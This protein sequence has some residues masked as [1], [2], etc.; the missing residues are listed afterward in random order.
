MRGYLTAASAAALGRPA[1]G[2]AVDWRALLA[3][4]QF[5][6]LFS[7]G[8]KKSTFLPVPH[9]LVS[10]VARVLKMFVLFWF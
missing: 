10:L 5:R 9:C 6:R 7:D 3:S 1:T 8:S 2:K 4:P